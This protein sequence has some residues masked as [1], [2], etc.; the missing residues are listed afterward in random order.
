MSDFRS[1]CQATDAGATP[2]GASVFAPGGSEIA[3]AVA[4]TLPVEGIGH[5]LRT[6]LTAMEGALRLLD[7][8]LAGDLPAAAHNLVDM[9]LRNCTT[10]EAVVEAHLLELARPLARDPGAEP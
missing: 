8:G 5:A 7:A 10:L 4:A 1:L 6:P 3:R 9:A 2:E